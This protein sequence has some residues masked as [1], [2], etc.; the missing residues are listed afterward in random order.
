MRFSFD[1]QDIDYEIRGAGRSVVLVH[2]LAT[3]RRILVDSCEPALDRP[4]VR[5]V[6]LDLP[7]HGASG[8]HVA[9]ASADGLVAALRAFVAEVA[10]PAPAVVAHSYGGYLAL[11]LLR[12][13][14]SLSGLFLACPIVQ[15]EVA[16]RTLPPQRFVNS[17]EG[18]TFV[19]D[20]ERQ[21]FDGEISRYSAAVLERFRRA[22]D[23]AHRAAHRLFL[24][25]VRSRYAQ[26][27]PIAAELRA[28]DRPLRVVCGQHD[29]W[30]GYAD[31]LA[32][33]RLAPRADFHVASGCGHFLPIER[34]EVMKE[35]LGEWCE[36]LLGD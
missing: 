31:A 16:L 6:Y 29:Y 30:A 12:E 21:A 10:G 1:G 15:P 3:D 11:G 20:E 8:A 35:Q 33:V 23:P 2:G 34:P 17:E 24:A 18:L 14:P 27:H 9:L 7:G 25:A 22:V 4:G 13:L 36:E 5:R 32:L 19:D 28:F 26:S